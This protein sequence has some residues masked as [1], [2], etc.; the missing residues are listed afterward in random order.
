MPS[1]VIG[2][3]ADVVLTGVGAVLD[4]DDHQVLAVLV[5]DPVGRPHG[6][7]DR[8]TRM[9]HVK[10]TVDEAGRDPEDDHPVLTAVDMGLVG[11]PLTGADV[12]T[13]DLVPGADVQDVPRAPGPLRRFI[14]HDPRVTT[15]AYTYR[16]S[17]QHTEQ[18]PAPTRRR[19][20]LAR[21]KALAVL[22]VLALV[23]GGGMFGWLLLL[24][25]KLAAIPRFE[26]DLDR[27]DRPVRVEG[28]AVNV[29]LVGVDDGKGTDLQSTLK[30]G[31]W[32]PGV[33]R[34]DTM[35]VLHLDADRNAAELVSIPR[36][37][38][39]PVPGYGTTKLNAA[40]SYGGPTLLAETV[41]DLTGVYLD[42]IAVIDWDGFK[43]VTEVIG[44]VD[45]FVPRTVYDSARNTTWTKGEHHLEG[46][47]ALNYVRQRYGLAGGDF[48]RVQRQQNFL[49]AFL[50]KVSSKG[51]LAN[52]V[53]LTELVGEL[54]DL[55][56]VDKGLDASAM[57]SLA[58]SS[59][60]IR[61]GDMRFA[62]APYLGTATI[63]G[64]SVVQLDKPAVRQMFR[65]IAGDD[66]ES[67]YAKNDVDELPGPRGVS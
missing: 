42:H 2:E 31:T 61:V 28:E 10:L 7:V 32:T 54:G 20:F 26:A 63:N 48:D 16:M 43:G 44:G 56:A 53:T 1:V 45:V 41:E 55:I 17:D 38:Y 35:M 15:T 39:V 19:G 40:F 62:T 9:G 27:P 24:N 51:V 33:F 60:G 3:P 46:E 23:L 37:S 67:W 64:A 49:R 52:P 59:R 11:H 34:S 4:L 57:R 66:F 50:A 22:L 65:A 14:G 21:H 25:S 8:L 13:F 29:L 36:D 5:A 18:A 6:H 30:S 47:E 58:L 12:H